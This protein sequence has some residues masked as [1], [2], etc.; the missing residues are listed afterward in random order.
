MYVNVDAAL[1]SLILLPKHL[2]NKC[3]LKRR[4]VDYCNFYTKDYNGK[5]ELIISVHV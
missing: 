4:N 2:I 3:N 5:L 1:L